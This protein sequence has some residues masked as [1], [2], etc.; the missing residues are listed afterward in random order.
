[1]N[2]SIK[3]SFK[4]IETGDYKKLVVIDHTK[5]NPKPINI[6][7]AGSGLRQL[8][9]IIMTMFTQ[10]FEREENPQRYPVNITLE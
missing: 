8:L 2:S 9:P 5:K 1:M 6:D 4:I 10:D 3:S 7:D